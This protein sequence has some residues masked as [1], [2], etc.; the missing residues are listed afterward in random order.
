[1]S[2]NMVAFLG[3]DGF[4]SFVLG[5]RDMCKAADAAQT[6]AALYDAGRAYGNRMG[7]SMVRIV[8]TLVTLG[9]SAATGMSVPVTRLPGGPQAVA[10][11]AA[12]GFRLGAVSS[13]SVSVSA[14]GTVTLIFAN[15]ATLP[16]RSGATGSS[17]SNGEQGARPQSPTRDELEARKRELG[18]DIR[19]GQYRP[20]E[21]DAALR[22]E[23]R[24]GPLKRDPSETGDWVDARG[25]I[26]DGVGP[27]PA[28]RFRLEEFV[29]SIRSHLL[30]SGVDY[31]V[32]DA[33]TLTTGEVAQVNAF[34]A[35][36]SAL[37]R[38]RIILQ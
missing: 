12:M 34:I 33:S 15:Q 1:M 31:V 4:R 18:T 14:T 6:F 24:V 27:V 11:G 32:V 5:Y 17:P 3:W 29:A 8:T 19:S 26:Y 25:K 36:L 10:N 38:A 7:P 35:R 28:S 37:D 21:A 16:D 22:L 9:L 2:A 13:G 20:A 23:R 30:K